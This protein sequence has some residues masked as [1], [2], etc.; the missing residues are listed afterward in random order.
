MGSGEIVKYGA[1]TGSL[2]K[3][4]T[5]NT[6]SNVLKKLKLNILTLVWVP[7]GLI[8]FN[9]FS[10]DIFEP[11]DEA[12]VVD[13]E[14][15]DAISDCSDNEV[16]AHSTE[17]AQYEA[18]SDSDEDDHMPG[19]PPLSSGE[20]EGGEDLRDGP[21]PLDSDDADSSEDRDGEPHSFPGTRSRFGHEE[22]M[23][24]EV[25]HRSGSQSDDSDGLREGPPPLDS[26]EED[27]GATG[28]SA[29][30]VSAAGE[31]LES[32][33]GGVLDEEREVVQEA[34]ADSHNPSLSSDGEVDGD[35]EEAGDGLKIE[36]RGGALSEDEDDDEE[37]EVGE[38]E[39][40]AEEEEEVDDGEREAEDEEKEEDEGGEQDK[41]GQQPTGD[42]E[43]GGDGEENSGESNSEGI[44]EEGEE[45][46]EQ[47]EEKE[48]EQSG[49][50]DAEVA[51]HFTKE[52]KRDNETPKDELEDVGGKDESEEEK[53]ERSENGAEEDY[54]HMCETEIIEDALEW[55][56]SF[57]P[58]NIIPEETI[59]PVEV[60][61]VK[62]ET[63]AAKPR[64]SKS[65]AQPEQVS[66][67][68]EIVRADVHPGKAVK[69]SEKRQ[70]EKIVEE[71]YKKTL[72]S[73]SRTSRPPKNVA[74]ES[75][76]PKRLPAKTGRIDRAPT[77]ADY[78][79]K[80]PSKTPPKERTPERTEKKNKRLNAESSSNRDKVA[81]AS[82]RTIE[83]EPKEE[84]ERRAV[85]AKQT[86]KMA[87][88]GSA[89][90]KAKKAS[91]SDSLSRN[92]EG[93]E[94]TEAKQSRKKEEF[95]RM[96]AKQSRNKEG[97][98]RTEAK[99][100]RNKAHVASRSDTTERSKPKKPAAT[101]SIGIGTDT[102]AVTRGAGHGER[103]SFTEPPS[104]KASRNGASKHRAVKSRDGTAAH[105]HHHHHGESAHDRSQHVW[106]CR[107]DEI[108]KLI[109]QK[110]SLLKE[111]ESGSLAGR[112]L[113]EY[114]WRHFAPP[115]CAV[116]R[117]RPF[118]FVLSS[119]LSPRTVHSRRLLH[120]CPPLLPFVAPFPSL[121]HSL[122][123]SS[124]HLLTYSFTHSPI[125]S[126][127]HSLTHVSLT[128][129]FTHSIIRS[130]TH[131]FTHSLTHSL[132]HS[133]TL[134]AQ[135]LA[136]S[137]TF[138]SNHCNRETVPG[139][140]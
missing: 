92:K 130:Y 50:E 5:N 46:E 36:G 134:C 71:Q 126:S 63:F 49:G 45:D 125:R 95:E 98:E 33:E 111:Y 24:K 4:S 34:A 112:R 21:P 90:P 62:A 64:I 37:E 7:C 27:G 106:L 17:R 48:V 65:K 60:P 115:F 2:D 114:C 40:E 139:T 35:A 77:A 30:G 51:E 18:Q 70:A 67:R 110:A 57:V 69:K 135:V 108:H 120:P 117:L 78:K 52:E 11:S 89:R 94:R 81:K 122:I 12:P 91:S 56:E 41:E 66:K 113:C 75:I 26:E 13:I 80:S 137:E 124:T 20:S 109:A 102:E 43:G 119:T 131:S 104:G 101:K 1:M 100:S 9:L 47:E 82:G 99:Q 136:S 73:K 10:A 103:A 88:E 93:I 118:S 74:V 14:E 79:G 132:T 54:E 25:K 68:F 31:V 83:R 72:V 19:P 38:G 22:E 29:R 129:S 44:E 105:A 140:M 86:T 85:T 42:T 133:R 16:S 32:D 121:P 87:G 138:F 61:A 76:D 58:E 123:R 96:E 97:I 53:E 107:D 23:S 127:T 3:E 15:G 128:N 59:E 39:K 84:K 8:A 6:W 28:V 116:P 55:D